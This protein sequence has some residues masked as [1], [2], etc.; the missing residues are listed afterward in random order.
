M[1]GEDVA[2]AGTAVAAAQR[3]GSELP[4]E[5]VVPELEPTGHPEVDVALERLRVLGETPTGAHADLYDGVHQR[6][7]DVL[8]QI[9]QR[10]A[11]R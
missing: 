6:L 8:A 5:M 7:Q 1:D 9:D 10:D 4:A 11:G 2:V 3:M